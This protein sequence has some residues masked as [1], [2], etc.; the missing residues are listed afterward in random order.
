[1]YGTI[2]KS[3]SHNVRYYKIRGGKK[4]KGEIPLRNLD[5]IDLVWTLSTFYN[6]YGAMDENFIREIKKKNIKLATYTTISTTHPLQEWAKSYE[7]YDYVFLQNKVIVERLNNKKI[8]YMPFGYYPDQYYPINRKLKYDVSFMGYPQTNLPFDQD[9]RC[10]IL[11]EVNNH[12]RIKIYGKGFAKR[13]E[14]V[15]T[16]RFKSHRKQRNVYNNTLINLDIPYINSSL[17]EYRNALHLKNRFFEIP[18]CKSFLIT[19]RFKEAEN[20]F[21]E[22]VHCEYYDNVEDL[23]DK[24]EYYLKNPQ[25]AK[26]IAKNAYKEVKSKHTFTHRF[27]QMF[28]FIE[29]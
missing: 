22:K 14:R 23:L 29:Q 12:F 26:I 6:Y 9:L 2:M 21:K 28:E 19:K 7:I 10:K 4:K 27:K 5:G 3:L 11:K 24:I 18:A 1:M 25:Q 15:K 20:I 8:R 16:Y 17:S 13:M